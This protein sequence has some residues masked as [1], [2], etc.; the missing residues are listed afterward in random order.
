VPHRKLTNFFTLALIL[1]SF[2]YGVLVGKYN[3][4]PYQ[5]MVTAKKA[6]LP[7]SEKHNNTQYMSFKDAQ[8]VHRKSFFES[9]GQGIYDVVFVG[10]S[11]TSNA[12]WNELFPGL[13]IANRG[14]AGDDTAG[15]LDRLDSI[16]STGASKAFLMTGINDLRR[17]VEANEVFSAYVRISDAL[18]NAGMRVYIQSTLYGADDRSLA[19][20]GQVTALNAQL[21]ALAD[22][23]DALY[24]VDLNA[25]LAQ[26]EILDPAYTSDGL[27]LN[28][29]AYGIWRDALKPFIA[30]ANQ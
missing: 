6:L 13:K 19:V 20:A 21:R 9:H 12:E 27:H 29:T 26:D 5:L 14:I 7:E 24:F 11:L 4:P 28:G 15:L 16:V 22:E 3:L 18:L 1:A 10:D 2:S 17:G 30:K 8:R 25:S 23:R